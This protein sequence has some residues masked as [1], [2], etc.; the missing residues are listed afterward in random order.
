[1]PIVSKMV[2]YRAVY[3]AVL[4]TYS[5]PISWQVH[6]RFPTLNT[7]NPLVL[8]FTKSPPTTMTVSLYVYGISVIF[9]KYLPSGQDTL[10]GGIYGWDR[11]NWTIVEK[12][13][14]SVTY[15]HIDPAD[16]GFPG[17]VTAL[18]DFMLWDINRVIIWWYAQATHSVSNDGVL[19]TTVHAS[20]TEKTPIMLTQ[21][22]YWL[23][24]RL[25]KIVCPDSDASPVWIG[26][27]THSRITA[28]ISYLIIFKLIRQQSLTLMET[29]FLQESSS[30]PQALRSILG[31]S[32]R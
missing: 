26:T 27:W 28:L 12:T 32:K 18:V 6:F 30:P 21:H 24:P 22:I 5:T 25:P 16:E 9:L 11:R 13:S 20:A 19:R 2:D 1:M 7:L 10:H 29:L 14:T 15:L 23:V 17:T 8:M 31:R 4:N 3:R